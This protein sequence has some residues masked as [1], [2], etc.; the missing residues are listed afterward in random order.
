VPLIF[1]T[2]VTPRTQV[3]IMTENGS[4]VIFPRLHREN[5]RPKP[6]ISAMIF[7]VDEAG[8]SLDVAPAGV[9][10]SKLMRL[11]HSPNGVMRKSAWQNAR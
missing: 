1:S 11:E 8:P 6:W 10:F 9:N 4:V 5:S 7:A 2:I 3:T